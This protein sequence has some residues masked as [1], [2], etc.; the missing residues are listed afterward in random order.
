MNYPNLS[1]ILQRFQPPLTEAFVVS[2]LAPILVEAWLNDYCRV[3][4]HIV[5]DVVETKDEG[6]SYLF[7]I[8]AERLI[9]A[10]GLSK[11]KDTSPRAIIA[12]RIERPPAHEYRRREALS[13]RACECLTRWAD[14]PTSILSPNS[15]RSIRVPFRNS[16][17]SRS[18]RPGRSISV[19]G[20]I[21]TPASSG[22]PALSR[23]ASLQAPL[24]RS[25]TSRISFECD[26]SACGSCHASATLPVLDS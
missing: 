16:N 3:I 26:R 5:D 23:A 19:T 11:G 14:E 6:F 9:A 18:R 24:R 12:T 17:A 25:S 4:H 15:E 22:P 10:W 2:E 7:D 21:P 20:P 8:A 13:P 1:A